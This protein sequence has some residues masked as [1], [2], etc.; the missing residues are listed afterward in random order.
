MLRALRPDKVMPGIQLYVESQIG[1]R[2][3]EPPPPNLGAAFEDSNPALPLIFILTAGTDPVGGVS[4][5]PSRRA[6][7]ELDYISLG[8]GQGPKAEKLIKD[9]KDNG[10]WVLLMN[11]HLYVSLGW[12]RSRRR[13]RTSCGPRTRP[14]AMPRCSLIPRLGAPER[15]QDDHEPPGH[16]RQPAHRLRRVAR[17]EVRGDQQAR[18][19]P[20]GHVRPAAPA[21]VQERRKF[22]A[23]GWNIGYDFTDGD[24]DM[25]SKQSRC[26]SD[27]PVIPYFVITSLTS[28]VNYGGRVTD[29]WDRR[30]IANLILDFCNEEVLEEGYK[31]S[32]AG[33]Y[34][35]IGA[36]DKKGYL[37]YL[38]NE[39]PVNASPDIFGLHQ[40]AD[41]TCAQNETY[42]MLSTILSLQPRAA[43][44]GGQSREERLD[45]I[46]G[47]ILSK[48][49][50]FNL[51]QVA[52]AYPTT[53]TESMNTVLQQE[54]I[55]YNKVLAKLAST[56]KDIR[57]A[58]KGEVVMTAELEEMGT[59]LFNNQ[60]PSM[61]AKVAYPSLKPLASWVPDLLRRIEFI[62][63][64][65]EQN[66]PPVFWISGFYFPQA[67]ITG[68]MQNHA[69]KYQLP[70]DTV[71]YG[72]GIQDEPVE[73]VKQ[74]PTDGA[75]VYGMFLEGARWDPE[76][77]TL[78]ESRAKELTTELPIV[79]LLPIANRKPPKDGFDAPSTRRSRALACSR[80]P[81]TRPTS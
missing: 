11:C 49:S 67:F 14:S 9:S 39:L 81:A 57:K 30:L 24:R 72:Y 1:R 76:R 73:S 64:W 36:T 22:G 23:L 70:I 42:S 2:F 48:A 29:K 55:R 51:E 27:Y 80:P 46:A 74:P 68:V 26:S 53:H 66:K 65:Y 60:V 10:R 7:D 75:Y 25:V 17:G 69:R 62:Q 20:Q 34:K 52:D 47:D 43:S 13:S 15:H 28:E 31:F 56:L 63:T 5:T 38:T 41:I 79:H 50:I 54:C 44:G 45:E 4:T 3:I 21:V 12:P 16:P 58:L 18:A 78:A 35:T 71:T 19:V 59:S 61:W 33:V 40:N 37:D 8:Q 77:Q 6:A 32:P